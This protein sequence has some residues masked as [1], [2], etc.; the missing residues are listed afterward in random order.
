[1]DKCLTKIYVLQSWSPVW[2]YWELTEPV[3]GGT[4]WEVGPSGRWDPVGGP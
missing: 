4:Q 2:C 1:L 3:G